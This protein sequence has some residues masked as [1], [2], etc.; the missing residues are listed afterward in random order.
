[1][2]RYLQIFRVTWRALVRELHVTTLLCS[3]PADVLDVVERTGYV[4]VTLPRVRVSAA[5]RRQ[6]AHSALLD[7][8]L[9]LGAVGLLGLF[10]GFLFGRYHLG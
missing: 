2:R 1:M 4:E 3:L 8:L 6:Y 10:V 5:P 7:L 9:I